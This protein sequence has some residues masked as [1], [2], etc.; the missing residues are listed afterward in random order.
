MPCPWFAIT[1]K[2]ADAGNYGS[3]FYDVLETTVSKVRVK[4]KGKNIFILEDDQ[5]R[6][7]WFLKQ[8]PYASVTVCR[9][10][11]QALQAL[12]RGLYDFYFLDRDLGENRGPATE[13]TGEQVSSWMAHHGYVGNNTLIHSWNAPGAYRMQVSLPYAP[14]IPFGMFEID[15]QGE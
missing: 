6:I 10:V 14:R 13:G 9:T 12:G 4:V 2:L 5:N 7:N 11:K 15:Y 1:G 3:R 8:F